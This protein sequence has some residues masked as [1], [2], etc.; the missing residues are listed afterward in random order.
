M[1][2]WTIS[3]SLHSGTPML[4]LDITCFAFALL[5]IFLSGFSSGASWSVS[6]V[7]KMDRVGWL[8]V[9]FGGELMNTNEPLA[10]GLGWIQLDLLVH[11]VQVEWQ[12]L[13]SH[14]VYLGH[15]RAGRWVYS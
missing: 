12:K 14:S 1:W 3:E 15:S 4:C 13:V 9:I 8:T 6:G 10:S 2:K 5:S 11:G 7:H